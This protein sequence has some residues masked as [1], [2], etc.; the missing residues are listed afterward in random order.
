MHIV[1]AVAIGMLQSWAWQWWS[2]KTAASWSFVA[3]VISLFI[4]SNRVHKSCV[5]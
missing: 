3:I 2:V 5:G 1:V 4:F